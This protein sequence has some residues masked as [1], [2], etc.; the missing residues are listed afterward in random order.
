MVPN[1]YDNSGAEVTPRVKKAPGIVMI[2][3]PAGQD[4]KVWSM[5]NMRTPRP[6][7]ML[8]APQSFG[9]YPDALLVPQDALQ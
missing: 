7:A 4:G 3:V 6:M 5:Q 9:F 2:D 8:N 1:F